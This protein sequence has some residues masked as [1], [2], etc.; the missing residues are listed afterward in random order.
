VVCAAVL[1]KPV[2]NAAANVVGVLVTDA[3]SLVLAN[4][5]VR[6]LIETGLVWT[7]TVVVVQSSGRGPAVPFGAVTRAYTKNE[8]AVRN[9]HCTVAVPSDATVPV[10][11]CAGAVE[12]FVAW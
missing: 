12:L 9:V 8:P 6:K 1:V 2:G 10:P 5:N 4:A 7:V 11:H 3:A